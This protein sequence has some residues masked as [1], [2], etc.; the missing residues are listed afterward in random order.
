MF[1]IVLVICDVTDILLIRH[2]DCAHLSMNDNLL[3]LMGIDF[4]NKVI[5]FFIL[6]KQLLVVSKEDFIKARIS[7]IAPTAILNR[8]IHSFFSKPVKILNWL[9]Y[10]H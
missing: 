10:E 6:Y 4:A 5:L 9:L 1:E 8:S 7:L 2:L 3:K